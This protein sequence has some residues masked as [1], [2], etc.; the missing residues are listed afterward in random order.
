M[1]LPS[2]SDLKVITVDDGNVIGAY[3][4]VLTSWYYVSA[5]R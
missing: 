1:S 5:A 2:V 3:V 4:F